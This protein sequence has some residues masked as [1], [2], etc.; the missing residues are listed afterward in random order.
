[1]DN[2]ELGSLLTTIKNQGDELALKDKEIS[3]LQNMLARFEK[4][5]A[6]KSE[7]SPVEAEEASKPQATPAAKRK[8]PARKATV[9]KNAT[10]K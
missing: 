7:V 2:E 3:K 1:M 4:E 5:E 8:A 6:P 9:K 10:T